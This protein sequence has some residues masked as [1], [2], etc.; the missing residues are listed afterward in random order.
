MKFFATTLLVTGLEAAKLGSDYLKP[1]SHR[2]LE[3]VTTYEEFPVT[4][5][6]KDPIVTYDYVPELRTR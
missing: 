6:R 4:K 2:E 5:Y 1:H 3:T